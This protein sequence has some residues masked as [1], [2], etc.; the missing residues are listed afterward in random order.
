MKPTIET[1]LTRVKAAYA[2]PPYIMKQ[3]KAP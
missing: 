1:N 3:G 2:D